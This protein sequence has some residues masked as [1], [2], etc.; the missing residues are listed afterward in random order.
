MKRSVALLSKLDESLLRYLRITLKEK[1]EYALGDYRRTRRYLC[2]TG[3]ICLSKSTGSH[4]Y[5]AEMCQQI[6]QEMEELWIEVV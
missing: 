6:R 1:V 4:E 2:A 5:G 3:H